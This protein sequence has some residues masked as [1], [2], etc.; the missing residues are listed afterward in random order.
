MDELK[1]RLAEALWI[2]GMKQVELA[3]KTGI[4]KSSINSWKSQRWQPKQVALAKMAQVLDVSEMWLA[5][6][7]VPMERP[8][9]QKDME[10][11]SKDITKIKNDPQLR[12]IAHTLTKLSGSQ[13]DII[14]KMINEMNK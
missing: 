8:A 7:D 1:N 11:F 14:E 6:C 10:S 9:A 2:R 3:E 5:G 12:A 13:L 4:D